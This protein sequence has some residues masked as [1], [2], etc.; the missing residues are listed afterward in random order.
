MLYEG[1]HVFFEANTRR[2]LLKVMDRL[3]PWL[4]GNDIRPI[5]FKHTVAPSGAVE[6]QLTFKNGQDA[7]LFERAFC[8]AEA[9]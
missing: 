1:H 3:A 6:L 4:D 2:S 5:H 7:A 9:V 8:Q